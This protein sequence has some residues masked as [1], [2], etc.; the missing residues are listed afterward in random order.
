M[1]RMQHPFTRGSVVCTATRLN[2]DDD[3]NM[4]L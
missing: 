1:Y 2:L 4:I 3:Y